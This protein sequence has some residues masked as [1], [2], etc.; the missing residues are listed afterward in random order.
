MT[1]IVPGKCSMRRVGRQTNASTARLVDLKLR[2]EGEQRLQ[3]M[4][5]GNS[6][7][8]CSR[9]RVGSAWGDGGIWILVDGWIV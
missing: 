2:V 3:S 7:Y 6:W 8:Y 4:G 5:T 1:V 9:L